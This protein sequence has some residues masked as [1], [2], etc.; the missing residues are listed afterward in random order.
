MRSHRMR[1]IVRFGSGV[2]RWVDSADRGAIGGIIVEADCVVAKVQWA[3]RGRKSDFGQCVACGGI[4]DD[5]VV[6]GS[7]GDFGGVDQ[8][9]FIVVECGGVEIVVVVGERR[10]V[11][12][13]GGDHHVA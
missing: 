3:K 13:R 2:V 8:F 9:E 7:Q 11:V 6:C 4:G 10:I 5:C 1:R 12:D